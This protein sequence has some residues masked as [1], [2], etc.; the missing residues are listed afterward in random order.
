MSY[1]DESTEECCLSQL[2]IFRIKPTQTSIRKKRFVKHYPL[3]TLGRQS[4]LE[5]R[6]QASSNEY[7]ETQNLMLYTKSKIRLADSSVLPLLAGAGDARAMPAKSKVGPIAYFGATRFKALDVYLN[8][9]LV[10]DSNNLY[11]YK[12][13][14]EALLSRSKSSIQKHLKAALFEKDQDNLDDTE[15]SFGTN[16]AAEQNG[17]IGLWKRFSKTKGSVTFECLVPVHADVFNQ[18]KVIVLNDMELRI[19][20]R[21]HDPKYSL[22][23]ISDDNDYE[24]TLESA[25]IVACHEEMSQAILDAHKAALSKQPA[26]YIYPSTEMK[27]FTFGPDRSDLSVQNLHTGQVPK[28]IIFVLVDNDAFTGNLKK[29]PLHYKHNAINNVALRLDGEALPYENYLLDFDQNQTAQAFE[30]L[31]QAVGRADTNDE[32]LFDLE[33]YSKGYS[34][35]GFELQN[36]TGHCLDL[37]KQGNLSLEVKLSGATTAAVT[38][39]VYL[40]FDSILQI[41]KDKIVTL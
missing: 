32:L 6:L 17:N 16:S 25:W 34:I 13:H 20:L 10:S 9:K 38:L 24:I 21:Q 3:T 4:P 28:R 12:A 23:A 27:F 30:G 29:N 15:H 5:F 36:T 40:Q 7:I 37:V 19:V 18:N 22:M 33:D 39:V 31:L 11:S 41:D 8:G 26:K 2:E 1:I 14:L 35:F